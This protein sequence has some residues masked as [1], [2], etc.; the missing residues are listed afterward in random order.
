MTDTLTLTY[1]VDDTIARDLSEGLLPVPRS[2][3]ALS[4]TASIALSAMAMIVGLL[5]GG[6]I[7]V[8]IGLY[9]IAQ[10]VLV[11]GL[12]LA[13]VFACYI[14]G[15]WVNTHVRQSQVNVMR[16]GSAVSYTFDTTGL[17]LNTWCQ[18]WQTSW[19]GVTDIRNTKQGLVMMCGLVGFVVPQ[20]ALG[21]HPETISRQI[22]DLWTANK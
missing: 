13:C 10:T 9:G 17:Q 3:K 11:S 1:T 19:A 22:N 20:V 14:W 18:N 5:A 21:D 8:Q 4:V 15:R 2:L 6:L 7:S 16:P 12:G